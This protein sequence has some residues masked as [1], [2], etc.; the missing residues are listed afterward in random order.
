MASDKI[1]SARHV[2]R[3][4]MRTKRQGTQRAMAE[5]ERMEPELAGYL[6]EEL[7]L[8]HQKLFEL[9]A[10]AAKTR[11]LVRRTESLTLV[12]IAALR[13]SHYDLWR[14]DASTVNAAEVRVDGRSAGKP[15]GSSLPPDPK[16]AHPESE[17]PRSLPISDGEIRP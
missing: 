7:S 16:P 6:M 12:C 1:V 15:D 17:G 2:L 13:Q 9:G 10:P 14:Q 11:W 3:A 4:L 5:L 8:L